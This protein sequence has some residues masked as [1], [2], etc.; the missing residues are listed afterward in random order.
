MHCRLRN[1]NCT[2]QNRKVSM[3]SSIVNTQSDGVEP[4]QDSCGRS[5]P[6]SVSLYCLM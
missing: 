3:L 5:L 2:M 4:K 1:Q 6:P